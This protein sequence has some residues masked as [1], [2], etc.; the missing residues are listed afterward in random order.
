MLL[1]LALAFTGILTAQN[2]V[3]DRYNHLME[4]ESAT[5]VFVSGKMFQ[6]AKYIPV[7]EDQEDQEEIE[8]IKEFATSIEAFNLVKVDDIA[9][10][11]AEFRNAKSK[12]NSNFEEL[13]RVRDGKNQLMLMIDEDAG[14]VREIVGIAATDNDEFVVGSLQGRID[15]DKVSD[16]VGQFKD[17]GMDVLAEIDE[18]DYDE[19]KVYPNPVSGSEFVNVEI[20]DGLIGGTARI[21]DAQGQSVKTA[22]LG[23][24]NVRL[25][26]SGLPSGTYFV[27]LQ[28]DNVSVKRQIAVIK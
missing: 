26:T 7:N 15:L 6:M 9:D 10:V 3:Q 5:V 22:S 16:L 21:I 17:S 8:S 2:F 12:L 20:P 28:K 19:V 13:V 24:T 11:K 27:E 23:E 18:I 25:E 4:K 14:I 1:L